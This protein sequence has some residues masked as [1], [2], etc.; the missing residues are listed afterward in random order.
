MNNALEKEHVTKRKSPRRSAENCVSMIDGRAYP[1]FNW[2]DGG[3]LFQADDR[4]FSLG[5]PVDVTMKFRLSGKIVDIPHRG[6]IVRKAR[7]KLAV[8]FE[9]LTREIKNKFKRVLDDLVASEF[10]ESQMV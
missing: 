4:L 3:M 9:P 10:A 5:A 7:D 1:V 2:S 6:R 8:Q